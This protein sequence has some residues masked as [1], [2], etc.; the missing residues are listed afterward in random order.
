MGASL[1]DVA[2]YTY[3]KYDKMI[4]KYGIGPLDHIKI[5]ISFCLFTAL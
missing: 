3:Y 1:L 2:K 4:P 5:W